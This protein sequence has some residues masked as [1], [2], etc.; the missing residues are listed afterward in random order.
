MQRTTASSYY[1]TSKHFLSQAISENYSEM[2]ERHDMPAF[3]IWLWIPLTRRQPDTVEPSSAS[4]PTTTSNSPPPRQTFT[5]TEILEAR[6]RRRRISQYPRSQHGLSGAADTP[7]GRRRRARVEEIQAQEINRLRAASHYTTDNSSATETQAP[8]SAIRHRPRATPGESHL[9]RN[10]LRRQTE[11]DALSNSI[12]TVQDAVDRLTEASSNLSSLL[13]E[14]IPRII[15]PDAAREWA[16]SDIDRRVKRRKLH[17]DSPGAGME[18]FSY[19]YRG[20]VVAGPLR[21]EIFSCDGGYFGDSTGHGGRYYW[22][23]N[24]LRNDK[25]VYCTESNKCNIILRHLGEAPFSLKKLVIKAPETGF[26]A[27]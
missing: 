18:G 17:S 4:N 7:E 8:T 12:S 2:P 1:G 10:R 26:S 3:W 24:L 21:M 15:S 5:P 9:Q 13:D 19:G 11:G 20:Q 23:D 16:E 14:P 25:S 22:P 27:P 6:A